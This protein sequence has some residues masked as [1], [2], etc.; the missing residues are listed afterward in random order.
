V[1]GG[2]ATAIFASIRSFT[3]LIWENRHR[4]AAWFNNKG[5]R[6]PKSE[7]ASVAEN[8]VEAPLKPPD[9]TSG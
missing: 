1:L 4:I 8:A 9:P 2:I 5:E 3:S 7:Q 6:S